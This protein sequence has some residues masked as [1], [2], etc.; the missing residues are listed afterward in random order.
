MNVALEATVEGVEVLFQLYVE[1]GQDPS[2]IVQTEP[3]PHR[4][5]RYPDVWAPAAVE[6]LILVS[7]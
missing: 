7:G 2:L 5:H 1:E 4:V 3:Y 6:E